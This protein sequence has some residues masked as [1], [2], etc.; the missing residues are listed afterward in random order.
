MCSKNEK[1]SISKLKES[2][3]NPLMHLR[4]ASRSSGS[5]SSSFERDGGEDGNLTSANKTN[6]TI[7]L[8]DMSKVGSG[9]KNNRY[10]LL[11]Q[12]IVGGE[13]LGTTINAQNG[14]Y[15]LIVNLEKDLT[16]II[17]KIKNI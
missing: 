16:K 2:T 11:S 17:K 13:V 8:S 14:K 7:N 9:Q 1:E 5:S 4:N 15:D 12:S 6:K 3:T 10:H